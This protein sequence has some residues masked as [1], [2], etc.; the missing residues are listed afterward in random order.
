M[1]FALS[2]ERQMLKD[3]AERFVRERYPIETRHAAT[4]SDAGFDRAIW[5]EFCELGLVG[6]L[7]GPEHGG[8]GGTGEDVALVFEA[9]GRG[10][11]VEPFLPTLLA[12]VPLAA[13][14]MTEALEA[15]IEGRTL[16][17]FAHYEPESRYDATRVATRAAERDGK[18][19]LT[20]RKAVVVNG[21]TADLVIVTARV[22]G[23]DDDEDGIALFNVS[24]NAPGVEVRGYAGIDGPHVAELILNDAHCHILGEPRGAFPVIEKALAAGALAVSAEAIGIMDVCRDGTLA[25]LKERKQFGK[26]IGSNQ[27]LQHRMVDMML[28][29][30]QARSAVMLAANTLEAPRAERELNISAA[31]NLVG[32]TGRLV[33]EET[34]QMHGGVAMTWEWPLAHYAK[35]LVMID[36]LF[37]DT[38]HHL[39]RYIALSRDSDAPNVENSAPGSDNPPA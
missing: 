15:A 7:I 5:A 22:A 26:P 11:V 36:H 28:E 1:D 21:A 18:W 25:Y 17:A 27:A 10:L 3:T 24:P 4:K 9:A 34:I 2:E 30:E 20:G 6:A 32:R 31:K 13:H 8:F 33:A 16:L 37:G 12:S 35:R 23:A 38:D 29:I 39:Q 19:E 14:G